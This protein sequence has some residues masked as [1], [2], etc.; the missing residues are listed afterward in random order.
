LYCFL[1]SMI[2]KPRPDIIAPSKE[3]EHAGPTWSSYSG[4]TNQG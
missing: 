2:T 3:A 4:P 1:A